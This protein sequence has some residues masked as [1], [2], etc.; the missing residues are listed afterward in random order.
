M[1]SNGRT[2]KSS[3]GGVAAAEGCHRLQGAERLSAGVFFS[4][5]P[6]RVDP[7]AQLAVDHRAVKPQSVHAW[8]ARKTE[9]VE[10][11]FSLQRPTDPGGNDEHV[12]FFQDAAYTIQYYMAG[13]D[14]TTGVRLASIAAC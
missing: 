9:Q 6:I 11:A 14:D 10:L 12:T 5:E 7:S 8:C 4:S 1:D 2:P 3:H 13:P